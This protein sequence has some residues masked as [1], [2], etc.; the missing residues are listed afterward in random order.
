MSGK[1][2][3]NHYVLTL[4]CIHETVRQTGVGPSFFEIYDLLQQIYGV[5]LLPSRLVQ[6]LASLQ[7]HHIEFDSKDRRYYPL[8]GGVFL[9]M[10]IKDRIIPPRTVAQPWRRYRSWNCQICWIVHQQHEKGSLRLREEKRWRTSTRWSLT[11]KDQS[12]KSWTSCGGSS[13]LGLPV[14]NTGQTHGI[15]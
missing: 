12:M 2:I 5:N 15:R 10:S 9:F 8:M 3:S 6:I 4:V 1:K 14:W 13:T 11:D 7:R